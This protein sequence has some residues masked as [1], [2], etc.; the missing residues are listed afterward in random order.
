MAQCPQ[1]GCAEGLELR[2]GASARRR[3]NVMGSFLSSSAQRSRPPQTAQ[4][5]ELGALQP[6]GLKRPPQGPLDGRGRWE[7]M[8]ALLAHRPDVDCAGPRPPTGA[9][10]LPSRDR[11]HALMRASKATEGRSGFFPEPLLRDPERPHPISAQA[12]PRPA[13]VPCRKLE[14]TGE[15]TASEQPQSVPPCLSPPSDLAPRRRLGTPGFAQRPAKPS[16]VP[17]GRLGDPPAPPRPRPARPAPS[18]PSGSGPGATARQRPGSAGSRSNAT[19]AT[20]APGK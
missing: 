19:R 7:I 16:A 11:P 10:S 12:R 6:S 8:K 18:T 1:V 14:G 13:S 5:Q 9:R 3:Q 17:E 20:R 15:W 4:G 2:F